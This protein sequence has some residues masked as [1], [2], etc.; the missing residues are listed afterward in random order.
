M[1]TPLPDPH[2]DL[3]TVEILCPRCL[4]RGALTRV[5]GLAIR[6]ARLDAGLT[7][8][9]VA[10]LLGIGSS[11]LSDMELGHKPMPPAT[12]HRILSICKGEFPV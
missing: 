10:D 4:G 2:N 11:Y 6:R 5:S 9:A 3:P 12:A 1:D 8:S 7:I